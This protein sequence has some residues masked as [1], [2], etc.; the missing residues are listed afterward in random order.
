MEA[1]EVFNEET[2]TE[3]RLSFKQWREVTG[4]S[5]LRVSTGYRFVNHDEGLVYI[6]GGADSD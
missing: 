4:M 5:L 1:F 3:V 2:Y 6:V